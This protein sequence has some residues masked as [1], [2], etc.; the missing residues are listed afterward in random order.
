MCVSG[1]GWVDV[2]FGEF[3]ACE[4]FGYVFLVSWDSNR[5]SV[6]SDMGGFSAP[7]QDVR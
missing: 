3:H 7:P 1:L 5:I 2:G 6:M 4:L